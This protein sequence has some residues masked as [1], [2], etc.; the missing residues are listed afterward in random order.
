[1]ES[2][3]TG[4][5]NPIN[6]TNSIEKSV[7]MPQ[8]SLEAESPKFEA[9][10]EKVSE[11]DPESDILK[12]EAKRSRQEEVK[13]KI[14]N[15]RNDIMKMFGYSGEDTDEREGNAE[16]KQEGDKE[17]R[18]KEL[19]L[20][21]YIDEI[22]SIRVAAAEKLPDNDPLR[23][24]MIRYFSE[25]PEVDEELH[26]YLSRM[27]DEQEIEKHID[28]LRR[29]TTEDFDRYIAEMEH[30][31][32]INSVRSNRRNLEKEPRLATEQE[33]DMGVYM[34]NLESQVR[35][36]V[37]A[38]WE[39]GYRTFQS[40]YGEKDITRQYI[41][42]FDKDI[43]I[44]EELAQYLNEKGVALTMSNADDRT[45]L[46]LRPRSGK[47]LRLSEWKE[48]WDTVADKLPDADPNNKHEMTEYGD[49]TK[50]RQAQ[51]ALR[52]K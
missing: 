41:D 10:I 51:D 25:R 45:T 26:H 47:P 36:A 44:P 35:D 29:S 21:K 46:S 27:E 42:F 38:L 52:N 19:D 48:I 14:K 5:N 24:E 22:K 15:V 28:D 33:Y 8:P 50:F 16:D 18:E 13:T 2:S 40:G 4:S 23:I 7:N 20:Q 12:T 43:A 39:K 34:D 49:L 3:P 11:P 37:P 17:N 6:I 9:P 31:F 30:T 32:E 1:M